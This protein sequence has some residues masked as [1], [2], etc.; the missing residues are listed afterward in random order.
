MQTD[1]RDIMYPRPEDQANYHYPTDGLLQANGVVE[2]MDICKPKYLD[3]S[4]DM[5]FPVVKNGLA[6]GT[7]VGRANGLKSISRSYTNSHMKC[8]SIEVAIL[9]YEKVGAFSS[10]GDSGA[11]VL[12]RDGGIVGMLTGGAGSQSKHLDISYI[13]PYW[14]LEGEIKKKY[15][16][17]CLYGND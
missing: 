13:I 15:H 1:Y 6:T 5:Y 9:S 8:T 12:D 14:W 4:D 2:D 17:C 3:A 16:D 10:Q 7:T 11:I